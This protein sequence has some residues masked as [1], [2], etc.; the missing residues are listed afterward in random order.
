MSVAEATPAFVS[1]R[2]DRT[3][4]PGVY[5][6]GGS[7]VVVYRDPS[8]RQRKQAARTLAEARDLKSSLTTDVR[9]G[10]WREQS[11]VTFAQHWGPWIDS[12]AG[13]TSRGFRETTRQDYRR[14]LEQFALPFFCRTRLAAIDPADVKRFMQDLAA[15][16]YSA[17]TIRNAV[18]PLRAMLADAAE[19]GI[20]RSNPAAGVRVPSTAKRPDE[21]RAKH[22]TATELERLRMNLATDD[23]RLLVDFLVA[24]GLRISEVMA[25][26]WGQLDVGRGRVRIERRLYRGFDTPKS[27]T[28]Q[29]VVRM[30]P[31]MARRLH[32]SW[33][34]R[35]GPPP[36][37][38]VFV[39]P[40]GYRLDY[41]NLYKRI[42]PAMRA[43]GIS[44][45][46]FHRMR[47]TTG[48]ELKRRG[49]GLEQIQA[50]LGHHDLAFTKRVYVHLDAEE[51][52]PDPSVLDDL[53]GCAVTPA[54]LGIA[55]AA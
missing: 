35:G 49:A 29:R 20:I 14:D 32:D 12:Y 40:E 1:R 19:D 44:H 38:P 41:S 28:S 2:L 16:G 15:K 36:T 43:A 26:D 6:R 10:E 5:K 54:R 27:R 13:R 31:S 21:T 22:L 47:H 18:A 3:S 55:G 9:R 51:D 7:Y 17:G 34:S 4:T 48:T 45:G 52:G 37:E 39:S 8:G 53:V 50:H 24:T 30:S 33:E 42:V 25:L 11:S 46:A 23:D